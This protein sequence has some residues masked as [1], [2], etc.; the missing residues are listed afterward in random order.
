MVT[1]FTISEVVPGDSGEV[2]IALSN[3]G[4]IDGTATIHII[5][6]ADD[7]NGI[8]EPEDMVD[9]SLDSSDGTPGGDL[10]DNLLITITADLDGDGTYETPVVEGYRSAV[11][12]TTYDIGTL[13]GGGT[14]NVKIS[15]SVAS[16]VDNI[17]QSDT[18]AFDI[19]F[20]LA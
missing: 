5:G 15:W 4:T 12:C 8:T 7:D 2:A 1:Y 13:S 17:I 11:E 16:T 6:T 14:I 19:E 20:G 10:C 18:C 3:V 9:G